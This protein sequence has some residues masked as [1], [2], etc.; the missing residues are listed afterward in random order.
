MGGATIM[1]GYRHKK[2]S[3]TFTEEQVFSMILVAVQDEFD[4]VDIVNNWEYLLRKYGFVRLEN[5]YVDNCDTVFI[6]GDNV[7]K[8]KLL[9]K[10]CLELSKDIEGFIIASEK[11]FTDKLFEDYKQLLM[12]SYTQDNEEVAK[13]VLNYYG[14]KVY[15]NGVVV[16]E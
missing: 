9:S 16:V 7:T 12:Y 8:E 4:Q 6:M 1:E 11:G 10:A 3:G 5:R 2:I 14:Y 15:H 13:K